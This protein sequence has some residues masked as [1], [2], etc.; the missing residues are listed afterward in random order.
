MQLILRR[1]VKSDLRTLGTLYVDGRAFYTCEDTERGE[2]NPD[3]VSEWKVPGKSAIPLGAYEVQNTYSNRFKKI[4][5]QLM[6]V[7]GFTGVRIHSGNTEADTEGCI[8]VGITRSAEGVQNSRYAMS[9]LQPIIQAALDRD[10][11]VKLEIK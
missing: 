8:L 7:P 5:P 10:E 1:E 2:G 4:L 3:T 11:P 6:N 9:L